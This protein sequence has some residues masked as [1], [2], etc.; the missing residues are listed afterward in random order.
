MKKDLHS[1]C[2][3]ML[4]VLTSSKAI[5]QTFGEAFGVNRGKD[6]LPTVQNDYPTVREYH[7]CAG[8]QGYP[9]TS[10][11]IGYPILN[12]DF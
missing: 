3:V 9:T 11:Q 6:N 8:D 10:T 7:L 2:F 12:F 1:F 4:L 5:S